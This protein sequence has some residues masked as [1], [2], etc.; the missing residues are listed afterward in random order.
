MLTDLE[1]SIREVRRKLRITTDKNEIK[2]L[3]DKLYHLKEVFK[4]TNLMAS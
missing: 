2:I 4:D 1:K 3:R